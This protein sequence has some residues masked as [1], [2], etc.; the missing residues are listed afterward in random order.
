M[1]VL[2]SVSK[3]NIIKGQ[4]KYPFGNKNRGASNCGV[5]GFGIDIRGAACCGVIGFGID[6]RGSASCSATACGAELKSATK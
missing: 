2:L 3:D 1:D 4:K 5:I 6:I